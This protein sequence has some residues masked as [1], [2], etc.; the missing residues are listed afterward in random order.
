MMQYL[1]KLFTFP[2]MFS[3]FFYLFFYTTT[4][5]LNLFS[6]LGEVGQNNKVPMVHD[7]V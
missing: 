7:F 4:K 3:G 6:V 1:A 2:K 5:N